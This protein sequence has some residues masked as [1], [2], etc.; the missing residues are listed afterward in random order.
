MSHGGQVRRVQAVL[1]IG[2]GLL[3]L[4]SCG[5]DAPP[6]AESPLRPVSGRVIMGGQPAEGVMVRLHPL[7]HVHEAGVPHPFGET[8]SEGVFP[9]GL[10]DGRQ[11]APAGQYLV[12]LEW[13]AAA[14]GGDRLGGVYA[15]PDGSG[16]TAVIDDSTTELPPFE[17][18]APGR[19]GPIR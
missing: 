7:N 4:V 12:T 5:E 6:S 19:S 15:E 17:V 11:G 16:L 9:L 1:T 18:P 10:D 14:G 3:A 13:P 8:D 2:V